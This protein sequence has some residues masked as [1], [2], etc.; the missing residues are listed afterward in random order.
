[1]S[2]LKHNEQTGF[3]RFELH[4]TLERGVRQAGFESP[5]PI[6]L[7]TIPAGLAGKDV[8]GL[9]QTGTGKTAAFTLPILQR[10]IKGPQRR[11]RALVVVPTR[12]LAEQIYQTSVQLGKHTRVRCVAVYGGV[13]KNSQVARLRK[14]AELVIA[15]PGRLLDLFGFGDFDLSETEVLVLDEADTMCEMGFLPDVRRI[16]GLVPQDRQTL[17]FSATMPREIRSLAVDILKDPE[18]IQIGIIAPAKTV[19]HALYPV[20]YTHLTLPTS[21][22]V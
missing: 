19:S 17:F 11:V 4:H 8:L 12:E 3:D 1:M 20:S 16:L 21:A 9:A 18:Q 14:G 5:R 10:L 22:L 15:C 2:V 6:Q 7:K 13:S